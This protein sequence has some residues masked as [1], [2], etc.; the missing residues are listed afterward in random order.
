[1]SALCQKATFAT[2]GDVRNMSVAQRQMSVSEKG[3]TRPTEQKEYFWPHHRRLEL[4][5][6]SRS[7]APRDHRDPSPWSEA[8]SRPY[9]RKEV[10]ERRV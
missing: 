5:I 4:R 2:S 3:Q 7:P 1:M 6:V 8:P 9:Q 10:T